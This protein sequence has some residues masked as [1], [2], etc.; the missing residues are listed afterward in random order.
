[1]YFVYILYSEAF[2]K[3]Y[4]GQTNNISIRLERHNAK[5]EKY[6]APYV[7]WVI[8][9]VIEKQTRSEAMGGNCC[10]IPNSR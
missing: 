2:D 10:L 3:F 1:M 7:P 4:I 9:C 8:R 5:K 6:T